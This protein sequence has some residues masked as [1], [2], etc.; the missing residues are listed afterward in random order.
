[1]QNLQPRFDKYDLTWIN[2]AGN[3]TRSTSLTLNENRWSQSL[4]EELLIGAIAVPAPIVPAVVPFLPGLFD[5]ARTVQDVFHQAW[6]AILLILFVARAV[7]TL[8]ARWR[9]RYAQPCSSAWLAFVF[10]FGLPGFVGYLLHRRWP[11]R[12]LAPP[13][14]PTGVEIFA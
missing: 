14:Q 3:V 11:I 1:H 5:K 10:L 2:P 4:R 7:T 6:P 9:R 12:R 8:A 13:P